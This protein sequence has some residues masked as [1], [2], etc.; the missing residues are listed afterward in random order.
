MVKSA[1]IFR[2]FR[3]RCL[4]FCQNDARRQV[5]GVL[6]S[7]E[8]EES[9]LF[10][11]QKLEMIIR[12]SGEAFVQFFTFRENSIFR[13][14]APFITQKSFRRPLL[15]I[16]MI[17]EV[18]ST[19][20]E[21]GVRKAGAIW[22]KSWIKVRKVTFSLKSIHKKKCALQA[23]PSV[24]HESGPKISP[25][26]RK[27]ASRGHLVKNFSF[28]ISFYDLNSNLRS[29]GSGKSAQI[30]PQTGWT[31]PKGITLY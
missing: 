20:A 4:K 22:E 18:H 29:F 14:F 21:H 3:F 6:E 27:W 5:R 28:R 1:Q 17:T 9:L 26:C 13:L 10:R 15:P 31:V 19:S 7:L 25:A 8:C 30:V 23:N 11:L 2:C 24:P 16:F 12:Q